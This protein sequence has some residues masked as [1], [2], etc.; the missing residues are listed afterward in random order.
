MNES[1]IGVNGGQVERTPKAPT[2]PLDLFA[3]Q[4]PSIDSSPTLSNFSNFSQP[5]NSTVVSISEKLRSPVNLILCS[6]LLF[7]VAGLW[8]AAG[9]LIQTLTPIYDS[10]SMLTY[11]SV[12]SL[13]IYFF[14]IPKKSKFP[15]RRA[16]GSLVVDETDLGFDTF[17]NREVRHDDI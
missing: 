3:T 2:N 17:T 7:I 1:S 12:I 6:S 5:N 16:D 10:P 13:Q 15:N 8:L 9:H 14:F 11:L 4:I